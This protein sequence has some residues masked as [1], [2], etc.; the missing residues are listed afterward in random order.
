MVACDGPGVPA[1]RFSVVVPAYNAQETLAGTLQ[2]LVKQT[3]DD[4]ECIVVDDGSVDETGV[5]AAS[6][7]EQD[8]RFRVIAQANR[9]TGGAYNTGVTAASGDWVTV[10]SADDVLLPSHLCAMR[11]A[12]AANPESD[13]L[14]CNGYYWGSDDA[15]ELVY[16]GARARTARSWT[17]EDA[18][19]RCFFSVGACYRRSLFDALGGYREE[20]YGEDYDFWL[21]ALAAGARHR[22][23]PETLTLHR[24]SDTQKSADRVRAYESDIRSISNVLQSAELTESEQRAAHA[25]ISHRRRLISEVEHPDSVTG[26]ARRL[27]RPLVAR[28]HGR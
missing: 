23:V 12:I 28:L 16:K 7:A 13:I 3:F 22:Y 1:P 14:S 25:A 17:L 10:C 20:I 11:A 9:G 5:V 24:V 21:R 8:E 15:R 18:L 27:L 4:W 26:R 2:A 6:F 19:D